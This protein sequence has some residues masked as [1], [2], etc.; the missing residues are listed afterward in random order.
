M[1]P[2]AGSLGNQKKVSDLLELPNEGAGNQTQVFCKNS[3]C[4]QLH[5]LS[6]APTSQVS[7]AGTFGIHSS[8]NFEIWITVLSSTLDG[9][10]HFSEL[11]LCIH[12]SL[13]PHPLLTLS[14]QLWIPLFYSC[15]ISFQRTIAIF[16]LSFGSA[17]KTRS[18]HFR[19]RQQCQ[20]HWWCSGG[21]NLRLRLS[22]VLHLVEWDLMDT[23]S[24]GWR[25][26]H[27]SQLAAWQSMQW[28]DFSITYHC[29]SDT[30]LPFLH[31]SPKGAAQLLRS[32]LES[33]LP[34]SLYGF[35][36]VSLDKPDL[37]LSVSSFFWKI[38]IGSYR[39]GYADISL[40]LPLK[41][42]VLLEIKSNQKD[43]LIV[44]S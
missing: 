36:T 2:T 32:V 16:S 9:N 7:V 35:V 39:A 24:S 19:I 14:S 10:S 11:W 42:K 20:Q 38:E 8:R 27:I 15:E 37:I 6:P 13:C 26:W 12:W 1:P 3:A 22:Q 31:P 41:Y 23:L 44:H 18:P 29:A 21:L 25:K 30:Q 4:S 17:A 28:F 40:N 34:Y 5:S 33:P 43:K